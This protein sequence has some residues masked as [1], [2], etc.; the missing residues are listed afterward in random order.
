MEYV[1]GEEKY[2]CVMLNVVVRESSRS[3][4]IVCCVVLRGYFL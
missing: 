4:G 1:I 3:V 2:E